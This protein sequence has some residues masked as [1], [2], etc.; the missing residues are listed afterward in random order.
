MFDD[1]QIV[2]DKQIGQGK[3]F[4]DVLQQVDHLGL[5]RQVKG[6]NRFIGDDQTGANRQG[7]C[8]ADPLSLAAGKLVGIAID[9][10]LVKTDG[11]EQSQYFLAQSAP[12]GQSVDNQRFGNGVANSLAG[13]KGRIGILKDHLHFPA[14]Q[15]HGTGR[16]LNDIFAAKQDFS[17]VRFQQSQ[18]GFAGG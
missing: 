1:R 15:T 7:P 6:R 11:F 13:I 4:L 2:G 10:V 18:Q 9:V 16:A 14:Q 12:F 5:N 3:F 17:P 8:D